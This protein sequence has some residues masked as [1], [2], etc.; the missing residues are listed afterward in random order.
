MFAFLRLKRLDW[1]LIFGVAALAFCS[2]IAL[3]SISTSLF[4]Q[5][6]AWFIGG[7]FVLFIASSLDWQIALNYKWLIFGF[8]I[9]AVFLLLLTLFFAPTVRQ[10]QSW[11]AIGQLRFQPSEL[12]KVSLIVVLSAFFARRH[13]GIAHLGNLVASFV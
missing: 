10:T 7:F 12:A 1:P 4:Y 8:Y 9:F 5:Q 3:S 11:L 13:V 6:V 2:L